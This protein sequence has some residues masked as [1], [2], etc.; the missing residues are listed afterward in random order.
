MLMI[1]TPQPPH[2]GAGTNKRGLLSSL[3]SSSGVSSSSGRMRSMWGGMLGMAGG[4]VKPNSV[5]I[6]NGGG[7]GWAVVGVGVA[8]LGVGGTN[9]WAPIGGVTRVGGD[10]G[11]GVGTGGV[12]DSARGGWGLGVDVG[13]GTVTRPLGP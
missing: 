8:V 2:A 10:G 6:T 3:A 11:V 13:V 1:G 12:G 7:V 9:G 5:T 4:G